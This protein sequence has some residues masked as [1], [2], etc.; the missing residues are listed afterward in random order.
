MASMSMASMSTNIRLSTTIWAGLGLAILIAILAWIATG[1]D[2][3]NRR[4]INV[5]TPLSGDIAGLSEQLT[6]IETL[7]EERLPERR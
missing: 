7:H 5:E 4:V 2:A 6:R 3:A 1:I